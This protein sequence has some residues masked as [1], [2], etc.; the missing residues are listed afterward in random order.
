MIFTFFICLLIIQRLV[1]LAIAKRNEQRLKNS[2]AIEFG[3]EHYPWMI[4]LHIGFF[5][6]LIMEVLISNRPLSSLW[7]IWLPLFALAQ[8]GRIWV[9]R[10]L[11][12]HWN[13]KI[14]VLPDAKVIAKGPYKY[15][16]HP[17]YVIV[18]TEIIVISLLFNAFL[19]AII[20]SLFNAWMMSVRIPLEEQALRDH[21]E[22]VYSFQKNR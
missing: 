5:T 7:Y 16:K 18:A 20:F 2:G 14:I 22:Y 10:S 8:W 19:T 15:M 4:L 17:N 11:G 9:I 1:E 12:K 6:V 21:A 3:A 13:T